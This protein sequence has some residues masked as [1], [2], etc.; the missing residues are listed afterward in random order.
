MEQGRH[1]RLPQPVDQSN[2]MNSIGYLQ[3]PS[4]IVTI[5]VGFEPRQ[6]PTISTVIK[7]SQWRPNVHLQTRFQRSY[8]LW[9]AMARNALELSGPVLSTSCE[10]RES[11]LDSRS[12]GLPFSTAS[13]ACMNTTSS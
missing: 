7:D 12:A 5:V 3:D 8:L 2:C 9:S 13:P 10:N 4:N 11:R 1:K 6:A